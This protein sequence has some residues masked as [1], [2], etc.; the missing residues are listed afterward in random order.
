MSITLSEAESRRIVA[1]HGVP[2]SPFVTGGSTDEVVAA[3]A[4][5]PTV[6]YP[7]VAVERQG[8]IFEHG[9][10]DQRDVHVHV[11]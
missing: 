3:G 11:T 5:D 10:Q 2:V 4:A 6:R 1:R 7:V 9:L 8:I